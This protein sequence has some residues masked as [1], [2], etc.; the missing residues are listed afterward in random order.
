[1]IVSGEQRKD[2]AIHIHVS[3]LP[4]SPLPSRP[5][6]GFQWQ[7][8]LGSMANLVAYLSL[9]AITVVIGD[10]EVFFGGLVFRG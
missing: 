4:Q 10:C 3:I 5:G 2:L 9:A 1:M 7:E 6:R 8:V